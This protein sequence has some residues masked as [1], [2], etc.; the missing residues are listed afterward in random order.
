MQDRQTAMAAALALALQQKAKE[1]GATK[2]QIDKELEK[3]IVETEQAKAETFKASAEGAKALAEMLLKVA[4]GI[5]LLL[6]TLHFIGKPVASAS[7]GEPAN[8]V[9]VKLVDPQTAYQI[10][11]GDEHRD[12]VFVPGPGGVEMVGVAPPGADDADE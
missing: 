1:D 7:A 12:I 11:S 3:L 8:A 9:F 2:L 6:G 5:S 4:A 10:W